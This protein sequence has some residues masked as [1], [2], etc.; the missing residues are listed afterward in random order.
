MNIWEVFNFKNLLNVGKLFLSLSCCVEVKK[1]M[2]KI[3]Y[4]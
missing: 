4:F 2:K 1:E 3:E